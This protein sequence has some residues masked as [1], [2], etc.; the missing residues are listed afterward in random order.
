MIHGIYVKNKPKS[1]W[2]LFSITMSAEAA[3]QN[4]DDAKLQA[5]LEGYDNAEV[6]IQLFDSSFHIPEFMSEIK[7]QKPMFN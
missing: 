5:K 3:M 7:G 1:K 2:H 4:I 6:A